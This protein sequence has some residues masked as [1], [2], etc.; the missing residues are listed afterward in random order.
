MLITA[1]R[2]KIAGKMNRPIFTV[3]L[4]PIIFLSTKKKLHNAS[5]YL[6]CILV[7]SNVYL[8]Y[9]HD[10]HC[11]E[12]IKYLINRVSGL[13]EKLTASNII[14][15]LCTVYCVLFTWS[16]KSVVSLRYWPRPISSAWPSV[17]RPVLS[18]PIPRTK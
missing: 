5:L 11:K 15:V 2:R 16:M 6:Y 12:C 1:L 8:N 13:L 9:I 10:M 14:C 7:L 4:G 17:T 18:K 3:H